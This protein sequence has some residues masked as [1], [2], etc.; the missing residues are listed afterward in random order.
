MSTRPEE[1][2]GAFERKLPDQTFELAAG[3]AFSRD[4]ELGVGEFLEHERHRLDEK[5]LARQRMKPLDVEKKGAFDAERL[6]C[7]SAFAL[8]RRREN[9][10]RQV[11]R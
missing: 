5:T 11:G 2:D 10:H 4:D 7:F 9:D 8:S 6:A 1:R 3:F